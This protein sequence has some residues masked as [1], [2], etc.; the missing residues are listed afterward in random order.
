MYR[1]PEREHPP[2]QEALGKILQKAKTSHITT[3][4]MGDYNKNAWEREVKGM[5]QEWINQ[6]NLWEL[7]DP[8]T[9]THR[10]GTV[11]DGMLL[12]PGMFM[13]GGIL[14]QGGGLV[15]GKRQLDV[16]PVYVTEEPN[17]GQPHGPHLRSKRT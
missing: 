5:L 16:H 11:T 2:Y 3:I 13:P 12:S 8:E 1:P 17:P 9:P 15:T 14:P 4:V 10:A 7:T 6:E